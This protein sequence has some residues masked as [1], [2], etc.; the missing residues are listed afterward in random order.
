MLRLK[1][2]FIC[3]PGA[4]L[5]ATAWSPASAAANCADLANLKI[6]AS[7]IGL[8]SG[9]VAITSAQMATVPADP[10]N[11]R[12]TRDY[13]KVLGAVMPTEATAPPV[14]FEVNLPVDWNGKAVQYGGGGSNG[15]LIT[16]LAPLRD[17][18]RDTPVPVARGF[19]TWGTDAGHDS[20]KLPHPRAFALNDES[21][22][23]MAYAAYKKTH[24]VGM[25]LARA[26]YDRAPA[27]VYFYGGSEGGREAL[28]MAQRFPTDFEGIVSVVPVA[29]YA[30][31]NLIRAK[32][33]QLQRE[34][35]WINPAKVKLIQDAVEAACD[36]LDGIEDGVVSA[37]EQCLSTFD[38]GTLHCLNGT[39]TSDTCL[40]DKQIEADRLVHRPYRYPVAMKNGVTAFPGW[41]YGS[42]TQPGGMIDTITGKEMPQFPITNEKTQSV[43]WVN[44]DGFVRYFFARDPNF[45]PFQFSPEK[46]AGRIKEISE[47]FDTTDPDLSAFQAHGGKLILKGNG[48]DYQRSVLQ[49][50][51]YY[52][53]VIG[54]MGQDRVDQFVRFYVTPGV[55]H[56]GNG[57]MKDGKAVP[58]KVDLLGALDTWVDL[59][60]S[61][62]SLMQVT[63]QEQ[64]PFKTI[65][66]R[67]LCRYPLSPHYD[68]QSDANLAASFTCARQ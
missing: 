33:T 3:G 61:P 22:V 14:N 21:L 20:K 49:E 40:S 6:P 2:A 41:T 46:F 29:N 7:E 5:M 28:M 27:K 4:I 30:G 1:T 26:F 35:G 62:D 32:L 16:G 9:G 23:N 53:S 15:V 55:N 48:A 25:R 66:S 24:D 51:D 44:A 67:P 39:D 45:D 11:P 54:K 52:K 31:S 38:V 36:K 34:G 58:A 63:Q 10:L 64:A 65:A 50:I 59:G 56:P 18:R 42:E 68:G 19:A 17:A 13:C 8:P 60:K 37:Y 43:A 57:V 47:M 12:T